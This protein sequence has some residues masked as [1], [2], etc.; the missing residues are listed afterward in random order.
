MDA[1][2]RV[3]WIA[4]IDYSTHAIDVVLIDEND[5]KPPRWY[6]FELDGHDAFAR[7]RS[8]RD[9][10]PGAASSFWQDVLAIGI[11]EA[12][13]VQK[14]TV[15]KLK[16]IQ[17]G[18]LACLPSGTLVQPWVPAAWRKAVGLPGNAPKATVADWVYLRAVASP[19][20]THVVGW[21]QDPCDAYC[22]ALAT[23]LAITREKAA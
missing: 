1:T 8:I 3:S 20:Y 14:A 18:V 13:G 4:G 9:T 15:A 5:A 11:E 19:G 17:G 6:G 10:M 2:T 23:C 16:A 7:T 22:I 21:P 12:Q